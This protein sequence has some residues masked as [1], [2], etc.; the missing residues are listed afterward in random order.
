VHILHRITKVEGGVKIEIFS[1]V[2]F[3]KDTSFK[4]II[5]KNTDPEIDE[6]MISFMGEIKK[7]LQLR[8]EAANG[9]KI[10]IE[11]D[12]PTPTK[13]TES[14][15]GEVGKLKLY[16]K[17]LLAVVLLLLFVNLLGLF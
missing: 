13:T 10:P 11:P 3:V 8:K 9:A 4:S 14:A 5:L 16:N 1:N 7:L 15:D 12:L 2:V 17:I 6:N